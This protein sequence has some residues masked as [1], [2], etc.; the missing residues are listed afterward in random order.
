MRLKILKKTPHKICNNTEFN[1]DL[2]LDVHCTAQKIKF[3]IKDF[4]SK[5]EQVRSFLWIWSYLLKKNLVETLVFLQCGYIP[6]VHV[7]D[8]K[9]LIKALIL[10]YM[11]MNFKKIAAF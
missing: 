3:P 8:D 6:L 10:L 9:D 4:F 11:E 2:N 7:P 5:Y 1:V